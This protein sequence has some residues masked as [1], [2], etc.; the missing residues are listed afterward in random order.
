MLLSEPRH[1]IAWKDIVIVL[2]LASLGVTGLA[3]PSAAQTP[4]PGLQVFL[5]DHLAFTDR[6]LR[7]L[8]DGKVVGKV[9]DPVIDREVAIAGAVWID[10]PV[11]SFIERY[12]D[13]ERFESGEGVIDV[14]KLSTPPRLDDFSRLTFPDEDL[15]AIPGCRVGDCD[16]KIDDTGLERL[17]REVDWDRPDAHAS[18]HP[19]IRQMFLEQVQA[20]QRDGDDALG[21]YRDKKRPMFLG[22]EFAE[23][24]Q[25]SPYLVTYVSELHR[26]LDI[27][28]RGPIGRGRE[29]FY[30][31]HNEFGLK[32]I[33]RLNHV[34]IYPLGDA[35]NA[36]VA[37]ASK[38]LYAS[39]YFHTAL[40][41]KFI[42]E[43][44]TR[45][46]FFMISLNRSRSDGVE[47]FTGRIMRRI[48]QPRAR[49]GLEKL[50]KLLKTNLEAA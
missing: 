13:I 31:A 9:L 8:A 4:S 36:S 35:D 48:A 25:T 27:Y 33:I 42:V 18:A 37:I 6:D 43:D 40:E 10:A 24:L 46:G 30:W 22:E 17:Q 1:G 5:Q 16:V 14:K 28:P 44:S 50:L 45:A 32:P 49:R 12:E 34:V 41:L 20:Y 29:F 15:D 23:L 38:Q 11:E 19:I 2:G 3:N 47:G 21:A 26:Y 39:H 7:D